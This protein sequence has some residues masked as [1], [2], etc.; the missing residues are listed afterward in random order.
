M[1]R[2]SRRADKLFVPESLQRTTLERFSGSKNLHSLN[3]ISIGAAVFQLEQVTK[4][5]RVDRAV[6]PIFGTNRLSCDLNELSRVIHDL[7]IF[8]IAEDIDIDFK[9][10][11]PPTNTHGADSPEGHVESLC[12]FS[13]GVDSYAGLLMA[14]ERGSVEGLFCAHSDQ[15]RMIHI[16]TQLVRKV[17]GNNVAVQKQIVPRIGA[18]GYA[19]L[20]GFLYLTSAAAWLQLL[21]ATS[22][23][24][25]E[26]G[27]TMYQ[28]RFSPVDAVTMTTHPYVVASSKRVIDLL[29]G[30]SVTISTPFENLTKAEVVSLCPRSPGLKYTHS[31]VT[32]RFGNHD[33]TCYGCVIRRL[34]TVASGREDVRYVRNPIADRTAHGGNLLSLLTFC[35]DVLMRYDDMEEYEIGIIDYY[36]KKDLF[37]RFALDNFAAIHRLVSERRRVQSAVYKLYEDVVNDIGEH[38]LQ[39]RLALLEA[40]MFSPAF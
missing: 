31:C 8:T 27:P 39:T 20:R 36:G 26:C 15:A 17:A 29:L 2:T 14:R 22:L 35:H 5:R 33:G 12:L 3:V 25:T 13:G 7:L 16:V 37:V 38:S 19:Q 21:N 18:R 6:L 32:Q 30:R 28:P 10:C 1:K 23:I 11:K 24:V 40:G 34:A 4:E 9:E